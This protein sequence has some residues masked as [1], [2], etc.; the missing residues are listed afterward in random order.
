MNSRWLRPYK[1][2]VTKTIRKIEEAIE[3]SAEATKHDYYYSPLDC[4]KS[5][6]VEPSTYLQQFP[7]FYHGFSKAGLPVFY[8]KAG[9]INLKAIGCLTTANAV[10]RYHWYEMFHNHNVKFQQCYKASGGSF[11]RYEILY[12][13]DL[14]NLNCAQLKQLLATTKEQCK[15]DELCF[16]EAMQMMLVINAP[17]SFTIA[18]KAAKSWIHPRI[19][20][21]VEI[22]GTNRT[23]WEAKIHELVDRDQLPLDYGGFE[24]NDTSEEIMR[25]DMIEQ[26]RFVDPSRDVIK[27]ETHVM[28]FANQESCYQVSVAAGHKLS[29]SVFTNSRSGGKLRITDE[30]GKG[31]GKSI[32][33]VHTAAGKDEGL[34]STSTHPT[35]YD[36]D[37]L[38]FHLDTPGLYNIRISLSNKLHGNFLIVSK[39]YKE[40]VLKLKRSVRLKS[41]DKEIKAKSLGIGSFSFGQS[42]DDHVEFHPYEYAEKEALHSS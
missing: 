31:I 12:I 28:S 1:F 35:R 11:K 37:K 5:L 9:M 39:T 41:D 42:G 27:E 23:L 33:I 21:K 16:P 40:I 38:G 2:N 7:Q 30:N 19:A 32:N 17:S 18:W 14:E 8:A 22:Y 29:L 24:Q 15:V 26:Y 13:L 3:Y 25:K 20:S 6:G 34:V 4:R 10:I 36:L